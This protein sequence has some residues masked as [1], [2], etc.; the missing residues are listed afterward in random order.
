[1]SSPY[2]SGHGDDRLRDGVAEERLGVALELQQDLGADLLGGPALA[3]DVDRPVL[4]AH[5]ALDR[6]HRAIGVRD[7]LAFGDLAHQDLVVLG[8]ADDRRGRAA[9]FRVRNDGGLAGFQHG[10]HR[11]RGAEVDPD[12]TCHVGVSLS[13]ARR[14]CRA[15]APFD[16]TEDKT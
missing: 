16:A 2:A 15:A 5:V 7:G 8:E 6:A 3:V 1:L 13:S 12:C 4:V 11:V 10:D 9:S 14:R